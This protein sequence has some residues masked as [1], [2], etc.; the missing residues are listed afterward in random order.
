MYLLLVFSSADTLNANGGNGTDSKG[1]FL[2]TVI[3]LALACFTVFRYMSLQ[4]RLAVL[5]GRQLPDNNNDNNSTS[6]PLLEDDPYLKA[7]ISRISALEQNLAKETKS[8]SGKASSSDIE[9]CTRELVRHKSA[10]DKLSKWVEE[11]NNACE[12]YSRDTDTK[13]RSLTS[14]VEQLTQ[15]LIGEKQSLT[16]LQTVHEKK[17]QESP[18][19]EWEISKPAA[20]QTATVSQMSNFQQTDL[21][22]ARD[23]QPVSEN[24]DTDMEFNGP[25]LYAQL[26]D[27]ENGFVPSVISSFQNGENV[28]ELKINDDRG[29]FWISNDLKAQKYALA[30]YGYFLGTGCELLN[31]PFKD[32]RIVTTAKG[33]L[34]KQGE[35]WIIL[36]KAKITFQ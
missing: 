15:K 3:I 26:P 31:Q 34:Q 4:K 33:T 32:C 17:I 10:H 16:R 19:I 20:R 30:D 14:Q 24:V 2:L 27:I 1:L 7:Q 28:Y 5:E 12:Q 13:I 9:T 35:S 29:I 22:P 21:T 11:K 23:A 6:P 25:T 36:S 18:E 8:N